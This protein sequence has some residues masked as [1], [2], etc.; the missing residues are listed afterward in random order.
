M[1]PK[2]EKQKGRQRKTVTLATKIQ[3]LDRIREGVSGAAISR[4]FDLGESTVRGIKKIEDKIRKSVTAGAAVSLNKTSHARNPLYEKMEKMLNIWIE[5]KNQKN[6]PLS[7]ECIRIKAKRIYD[8]ICQEEMTTADGI[9][10]KFSASKGWLDNFKKR[11]ALPD[12][13][14]R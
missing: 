12:M 10:P 4:E 8:H 3:V 6:M 11:F 1:A 13:P 9:I 2:I 7:G 5:D 14:Y